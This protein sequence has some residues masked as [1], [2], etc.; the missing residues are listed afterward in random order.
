MKQA[1]PLKKEYN[2]KQTKVF[3]R[4]AFVILAF[5]SVS[6]T[7]FSYLQARQIQNEYGHDI[8]QAYNSQALINDLFSNKELSQNILRAHATAKT[9]EARD[10]L[11]QQFRLTHNAHTVTLLTLDTLI[12]QPLQR[13]ILNELIRDMKRYYV[14]ADSL[15]KLNEL[16]HTTEARTYSSNFIGPFYARH[17][18]L[19][20]QLSNAVTIASKKN[21][22]NAISSLAHVVDEYVILLLVTLAAVTIVAFI[23]RWIFKSLHLEN[24][25]LNA[26]VQERKHLEQALKASQKEFKSLFDRNPIPMWVYN[27]HSLEFLEVNEAAIKEYGYSRDEF[28]TMTLKQIRPETELPKFL[29]RINELGKN[30]DATGRQYLHKRKGGSIFKVE[31]RSHDLPLR[32]EIRTRLVVAVNIQ[33]RE[34]TLARLKKSEHLLREVSSSIP[35]AVYQLLVS[36]ELEMKFLFLNDGFRALYGLEIE[37]VYRDISSLTSVIHEKDIDDVFKTTEIARRTLTP[38]LHEFRIWHKS[39]GRIKWIR[40]HGLPTMKDDGNVL[41]NGTLIDITDQKEAQ[42]QLVSIEANLRALLNSSPQSIYLLNKDRKIIAF[43]KVAEEEVK[44]NRLIPLVAGHDILTYIKPSQ[45]QEFLEHHGNA[46]QGQATLYE[47]GNSEY[48]H[49]VAFKPVFD[50]KNEVIGVT[51][52]ILDRSE[53]KKAIEL[54]KTNEAQLAKA[55]QIAK[56]GSWELDLKHDLMTMSRTLYAIYEVPYESFRPTFTSI[57][58]RIYHEDRTRVLREY[59]YA[60]ANGVELVCEHRIVTDNGTI[61]YLSQIAEIERDEHGVPIK[62]SGTAQDI[63]DR[64]HA[65]QEITNAKNLLQST[66][67]NIPEVIFSADENLNVT[68]VSPKCREI[69]GYSEQEFLENANLWLSTIHQEDKEH[70]LLET[71]PNLR[72]G[73]K[74]NHEVRMRTRDG[75]TK[76]LLLRISPMMDKNGRMVRLDGSASD[77]TEYKKAEQRQQ[78]LTEQLLKQNQNLQQFAYIVSHNLRSPIANML[79]LASIYDKENVTAP[80]NQKVMQSMVESAYLLDTTIRDLNELLTI[81][82]QAGIVREEVYFQELLADACVNLKNEI[83]QCGVSF[84]FDFAQAPCIKTVRSYAYSILYNLVS[85][86]IKYSAPSRKPCVSLTTFEVNGYICLSIRDNG[87]GIDLD[88]QRDKIFGLYKRF[89]PKIQGKGIGLHLVKTQAELLGGKVEVESQPDQGTIFNVYFT[90]LQYHEDDQKSN[91]N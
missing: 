78:K 52:S 22:D 71:I 16:G 27:Q 77:M 21:A 32:K 75:K 38:W 34:E 70:F 57:L 73:L 14:H 79:G 68:Y 83:E 85:N 47:E 90:Q 26:E 25:T 54:I 50:K 8:F 4:L 41:F 87:L 1:P 58:Q 60:L 40:G 35:G 74:T 3:I 36:P 10:S 62:V 67:E 86:A 2:Y 43:N 48:W 7:L 24:D 30:E 88:K 37:D 46:L 56:I 84:R 5:V 66:I 31:L 49:E 15:V 39:E 11:R 33:E 89:H 64:K 44:C 65:E 6:V 29:E 20:I 72:T 91:V 63:T 51:L 53:Q 81:R 59:E 76:W 9:Q 69:T 23:L 12:S 45:H 28:L 61:K 19:L 18:E 13:K 55:Q 42:A 17:Q 80:V 82:S